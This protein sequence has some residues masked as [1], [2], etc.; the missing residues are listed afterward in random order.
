MKYISGSMGLFMGAL[1]VAG[2]E[3]AE[4]TLPTVEEVEATYAYSGQIVATISGNVVELEVYQPSRQLRRGGALWAKVGPYVFLFSEETRQLFETHNGLAAVRVVTK[5][6]GG[7]EVARA[8]LVRDE[9]NDVT[10]R[11]ALNISGLARRDGTEQP[12]RLGDLVQWGED[13]TEFEYNPRYTRR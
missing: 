1:F 10:W 13:H 2:C 7:R 9:L 5:A 11:R 6:P 12:T 4:L 8:T 3:P